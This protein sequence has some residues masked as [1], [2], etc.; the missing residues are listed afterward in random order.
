M[1]SLV[2]AVSSCGDAPAPV[3][4]FPEQ[5][6]YVLTLTCRTGDRFQDGVSQPGLGPHAQRPAGHGGGR[7]GS[8]ND[9][10]KGTPKHGVGLN[11][12]GG[13]LLVKMM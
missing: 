10:K 3:P 11:G 12:P 1:L 6:V 5:I 4:E 2:S 7:I 13:T 9:L 8:Q